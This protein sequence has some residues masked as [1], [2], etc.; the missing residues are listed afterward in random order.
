MA[1]TSEETAAHLEITQVLYLYC[2]GIDRGSVALLQSVYHP[3]AID[4]RGPYRRLGHEYAVD[5]ITR[6]EAHKGAC[7]HHVT[8]VLIQLDGDKAAVES[9]FLAISPSADG[10]VPVGGR[11]LDRFERRDGQWR[12]AYRQMV[13]DW[14]RE[15]MVM[16]PSA[17]HA[18]FPHGDRTDKDMSFPG[19]AWPVERVDR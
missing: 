1:M 10:L 17:R 13:I 6:V 15:P 7:Q 9:Y 4:E 19:F 8:N 12:I 5:L 18:E 2:R 11:Y 16:K 3:D 14:S